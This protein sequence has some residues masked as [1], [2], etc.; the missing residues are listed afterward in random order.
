MI[1]FRSL[2]RPVTILLS[3][4][5]VATL[6]AEVPTSGNWKTDANQAWQSAQQEQRLMLLFITTE[7][8]LYCR[9]MEKDTFADQ[10]VAAGIRQNCIPVAVLAENN[11]TLVQKFRVRSYP[12]TVIISPK[13]GVVDYIVGYL[14]PDQFSRRLDA[15][16]QRSH[17]AA[18]A[19]GPVGP[20]TR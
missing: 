12:T 8:C 19:R 6:P 11:E 13:S 2:L 20:A 5:V 9:K 17:T 7:N 3:V 18:V 14:G 15:A 1:R 10:K 16:T 4:G